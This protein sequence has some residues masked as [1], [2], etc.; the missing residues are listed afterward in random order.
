MNKEEK[1]EIIEE[2][3]E[4]AKNTK[5]SNGDVEHAIKYGI[6]LC[7]DRLQSRTKGGD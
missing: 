2:F 4:I 1:Q 5:H 3:Q 6:A 7:I